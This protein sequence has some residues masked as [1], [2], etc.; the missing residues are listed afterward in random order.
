[1]R[2]LKMNSYW[3]VTLTFNILLF[4]HISLSLIVGNASCVQYWE[5]TS[6]LMCGPGLTIRI[7]H[8]HARHPHA[9]HLGLVGNWQADVIMTARQKTA[10][11]RQLLH[12]WNI[13]GCRVLHNTYYTE[14]IKCMWFPKWKNAS[15][16]RGGHLKYY[17][18][19]VAWI[20]FLVCLCFYFLNTFN[21]PNF[22]K[23]F[24]SLF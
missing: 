6:V 10:P 14:W 8:Y 23:T 4:L 19:I 1:M 18:F 12:S 7:I 13:A 15:W 2:L 17:F 16:K 22:C 9:C 3:S 21:T 20:G 11:S 24:K 5:S